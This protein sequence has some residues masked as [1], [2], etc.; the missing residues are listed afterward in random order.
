[1]KI[2]KVYRVLLD[3]KDDIIGPQDAAP[4]GCNEATSQLMV[5]DSRVVLRGGEAGAGLIDL[6]LRFGMSYFLHGK[7]WLYFLK[8]KCQSGHAEKMK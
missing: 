1:M 7:L 8:T 3:L 5:D 4:D 2:R 6:E